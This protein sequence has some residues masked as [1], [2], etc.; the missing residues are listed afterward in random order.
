MHNRIVY[1][2][3]STDVEIRFIDGSN[4]KV[5]DFADE[6]RALMVQLNTLY[7]EADPHEPNGRGWESTRPKL[8]LGIRRKSRTAEYLVDMFRKR[9]PNEIKV[10]FVDKF[11]HQLQH[12]LAWG[13][14]GRKGSR[15]N[16]FEIVFEFH[17][18]AHAGKTT[19]WPREKCYPSYVRV[20]S[21]QWESIARALR[22]KGTIGSQVIN[23]IDGLKREFNDFAQK[24]E[25]QSRQNTTGP[26][27][28]IGGDLE[29]HGD[30]I[31]AGGDISPTEPSKENAGRSKWKLF[32]DIIRW[33][34]ARLFHWC[35]L[36]A[37]WV[38]KFFT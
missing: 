9:S 18:V 31:T 38:Q 16:Y 7:T 28:N 34:F 37:Q 1:D 5:A 26:T 21:N 25:N 15:E 36:L 32:G 11:S 29:V 19:Q 22:R 35:I 17:M 27:I 4:F 23:D 20:P 8:W 13:M 12:C 3:K 33:P 2:P 24:M 10:V 30:M 6:S 14:I